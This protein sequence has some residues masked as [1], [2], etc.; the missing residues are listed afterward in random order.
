MSP[1]ESANL[2]IINGSRGAADTSGTGNG[3]TAKVTASEK[4]IIDG[5]SSTDNKT[6]SSLSASSE[7]GGKAGDLNISTRVLEVLNG[8]Q[9]AVSSKGENSISGNM[10]LTVDSLLLKNQA[11][12]NA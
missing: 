5:K 8:G 4:I 2:S 12:I 11:S 3:G 9:I 7:Q 6:R 10:L 1:L